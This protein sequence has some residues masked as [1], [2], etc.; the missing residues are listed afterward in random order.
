MIYCSYHTQSAARV[1][2]TSCNRGLCPACDHR[3]KGYAYCQDC[4]VMGIESLSR[5]RHQSGR[6]KTRARLAALCAL[7]PG[8]GAVYNRQNIKAVVHFVSIIGLFNLTKL[9]IMPGLFSLAGVAVYFYTMM[10]AYRTAARISQGETA[11]ADEARFKRR[12]AKHAPTLGIGL[13][14]LGA[15]MVIQILRPFA[16]VNPARLL[17]VALIILGG[18]MLTRYFKRSSGDATNDYNRPPYPMIPGS[19][20]DPS[21]TNVRPMARFGERR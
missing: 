12:L 1:Q 2:C 10:D 9:H 14:G 21:Q 15:L 8:M 18:Y 7:L 17:P 5:H 6:S 13:I 4:I 16:F 3:I 20:G 11:E 19:F